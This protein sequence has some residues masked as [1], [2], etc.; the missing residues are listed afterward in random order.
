MDWLDNFLRAT[1]G[2]PLKALHQP[3]DRWLGS[4][5]MSIAMLCA[6]GLYGMALVWVWRLKK[7]FVFRASPSQASKYDLRIWATL[8]VIPYVLVYLWLGR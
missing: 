3:I 2:P 7:E 4:L 5:P 1:L 6:I 8:V